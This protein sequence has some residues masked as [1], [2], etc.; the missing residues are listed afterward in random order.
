MFR[1][2][3]PV[4]TARTLAYVSW[5]YAHSAAPKCISKKD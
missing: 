2:V 1:D 5:W 3:I 4:A